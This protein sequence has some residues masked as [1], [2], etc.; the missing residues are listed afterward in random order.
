MSDKEI[1]RRKIDAAIEA[2]KSH[3]LRWVSGRSQVKLEV[4]EKKYRE[5][6]DLILQEE[7]ER[8]MIIKAIKEK[9]PLTPKEI[10]QLTGIQPNKAV[11]HL[12]ALK[13]SGVII[14]VG[15]KDR[16][17]LYKLV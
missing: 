14:E 17:C 5:V 12:I 1:L 9:G 2:F 15:E 13:K 11:R 6:L 8:H 4:D 7:I 16:W 10:S 3:R